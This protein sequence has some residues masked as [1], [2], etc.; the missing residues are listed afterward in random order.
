[1]SKKTSFWTWQDQISEV[2]ARR[3]IKAP[4]LPSLNQNSTLGSKSEFKRIPDKE[5]RT[6]LKRI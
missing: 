4:Q 2:F 3:N 5:R 1:M 6:D